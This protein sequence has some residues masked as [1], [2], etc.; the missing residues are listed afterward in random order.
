MNDTVQW[1][2]FCL[3]TIWGFILDIIMYSPLTKN[4]QLSMDLTE[5]VRESYILYIYYFMIPY[6]DLIKV[7][8]LFSLLCYGLMT[9][10]VKATREHFNLK[11]AA[12]LSLGGGE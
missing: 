8:E 2:S 6:N 9:H 4:D 12:R 11:N 3:L 1:S 5:T 7:I 10:Q